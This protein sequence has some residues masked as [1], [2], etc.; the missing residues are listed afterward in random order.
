MGTEMSQLRILK[1]ILHQVVSHCHF[2]YEIFQNLKI[3]QKTGRKARLQNHCAQ[4]VLHW[5]M[6]LMQQ[7]HQCNVSQQEK[8]LESQPKS[9]VTNF[10]CK[11]TIATWISGFPMGNVEL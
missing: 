2:Q 7:M 8:T 11:D 9:V 4:V 10:T 3:F 5:E 6:H 1:N